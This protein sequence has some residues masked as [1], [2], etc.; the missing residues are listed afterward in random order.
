MDLAYFYISINNARSYRVPEGDR[1]FLPESG[2]KLNLD[3]YFDTL[4][5]SFTAADFDI[6]M[7][8]WG[9]IGP[10][11]KLV[12]TFK[13]TIHRSV[14]LVCSEEGE[15][16]CSGN[17]DGEWLT[18]VNFSDQKPVK[19]QILHVQV[20][21]QPDSKRQTRYVYQFADTPY[22]ND[23]FF[24]VNGLISSGCGYIIKYSIRQIE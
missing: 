12:G 21:Q 19:D 5:N 6:S 22:P 11:L 8:V 10:D 15:G 13:T 1:M 9:W 14:L 17:G 16:K 3:D 23:L 24:D 18:E 4:L 20:D 7:E 2:V